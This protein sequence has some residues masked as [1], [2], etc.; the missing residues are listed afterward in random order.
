MSAGT[1]STTRAVPSVSGIRSGMLREA[2]ATFAIAWREILRRSRAR[3]RS[4]SP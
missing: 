3:C 1:V 2:N 4:P